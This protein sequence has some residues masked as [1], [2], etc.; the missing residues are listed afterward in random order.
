M[1]SSAG[2]MDIFLRN[3][4]EG[5]RG[6]QQIGDFVDEGIV[7]GDE[8]L[9]SNKEGGGHEDDTAEGQQRECA[10]REPSSPLG[11]FGEMRVFRDFFLAAFSDGYHNVRCFNPFLFACF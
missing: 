6:K 11:M 5:L 2:N 8:P 1:A 3:S 10:D 4:Y 9:L 7:E